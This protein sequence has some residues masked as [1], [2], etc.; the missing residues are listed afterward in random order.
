MRIPSYL[1]QTALAF[2]A[3]PLLVFAVP[4]QAAAPEEPIC[5]E[6]EI[7]VDRLVQGFGE[8]PASVGL[9]SDGNVVEVFRSDGGSWTL[10]ITKP[11]GISCVIAAGEAWHHLDAAGKKIGERK[12]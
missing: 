9:G 7:F 10:L 1:S 8:R 6:R 11:G 3:V 12:S 5:G 4:T 2:A